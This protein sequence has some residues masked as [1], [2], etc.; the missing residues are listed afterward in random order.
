MYSILTH[1]RLVSV[2][3][4]SLIDLHVLLLFL[5]ICELFIRHLYFNKT[6]SLQNMP[7]QLPY[8]PRS[9]YSKFD[10]DLRNKGFQNIL[11]NKNQTGNFSNQ[12]ADFKFG[13]SNP[14]GQIS[15]NNP[16]TI[17]Q[18]KEFGSNVLN[19]FVKNGQMNFVKKQVGDKFI[20]QNQE[21]KNI[22][23]RPNQP[24]SFHNNTIT[25]SSSKN[26]LSTNREGNVATTGPGSAIQGNLLGKF[27]RKVAGGIN[28][29]FQN[30]NRQAFTNPQARMQGANN[31]PTKNY[32]GPNA[33]YMLANPN[34]NV[35]TQIIGT[36]HTISS[37][38]NLNEHSLGKNAKFFVNSGN[39]AKSMQHNHQFANEHKANYAMTQE[40]MLAKIPQSDKGDIRS[41]TG[42]MMSQYGI[43]KQHA[44]KQDTTQSQQPEKHRGLY[45][46]AIRGNS[47]STQRKQIR[48]GSNLPSTNRQQQAS[49]A[50]FMKLSRPQSVQSSYS[51][52]VDTL[53]RQFINGHYRPIHLYTRLQP[54]FSKMSENQ[55]I[56][57]GRAWTMPVNGSPHIEAKSANLM[58]GHRSKNRRTDL[59]ATSEYHHLRANPRG[60]RPGLKSFPGNANIY[61]FSNLQKAHEHGVNGAQQRNIY[62]SEFQPRLI[63]NQKII[64]KSMRNVLLMFFRK[65]LV[66]NSKLEGLKQKLYRSGS[67]FSIRA[68][69]DRLISQNQ[70]NLDVSDLNNFFMGLNFNYNSQNINKV[71]MYCSRTPQSSSQIFVEEPQPDQFQISGSGKLINVPRP[72][73]RIRDVKTPSSALFKEQLEDFFLPIKDEGTIISDDTVDRRLQNSNHSI[74]NE[75]AEFHLLRQIIILSMRKLDDLGWVIRSLQLF[76]LDEIFVAAKTGGEAEIS[77]ETSTVKIRES[78]NSIAPD[79]PSSN[80]IVNQHGMGNPRDSKLLAKFVKEAGMETTLDAKDV[81]EFLKAHGAD[82]LAGDLVYIFK[83]IG[84]QAD[85]VTK[86][87]FL[88]Y[89][90]APFWNL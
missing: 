80:R 83:E 11:L 75:E 71:M 76:P 10:Q 31:D 81:A 82:Y 53:H 35:E 49:Q 19:K 16:I 25:Q 84:S 24:L 28:A 13:E 12:T 18:N 56:R 61:S 26:K 74:S 90:S 41:V 62:Q 8:S 45:S 88:Q 72:S 65:V 5:N 69:I 39:K 40:G 48:A 23:V 57:S 73:T 4:L 86:A 6:P 1:W 20:L 27:Q 3:D 64:N 43:I 42:N 37:M 50:R 33:E 29:N 60:Q 36:N 78:Q 30:G 85:S 2:A 79:L 68:I 46:R 58:G 52:G 7:V 59:Q 87:E 9:N 63:N 21:F 44:D 15:T 38:N 67:N 77:D 66:F 51:R 89:L 34:Q 70:A 47:N 22:I 54:A 32:I 17:L 14:N 55:S